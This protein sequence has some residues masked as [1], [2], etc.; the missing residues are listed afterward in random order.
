[1]RS[2]TPRS[3]SESRRARTGRRAGPRIA[4][5]SADTAFPVLEQ[6]W[7]GDTGD[8]ERPVHIWDDW[9]LFRLAEVG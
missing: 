2:R 6:V 1:M 9:A 8:T 4:R 5:E 7:A 3:A